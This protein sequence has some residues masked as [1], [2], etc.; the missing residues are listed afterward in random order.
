[1]SGS[2]NAGKMS[3]EQ[4]A[5]KIKAKHSL[6]GTVELDD[7]WFQ[8]FIKNFEQDTWGQRVFV[9]VEHDPRNGVASEITK[10]RSDGDRFL[11]DLSWKKLGERAFENGHIYFS[12]DFTD[13]YVDPETQEHHGP[14]L[15][16][17][18]M[19]TR[20][21]IKRQPSA[22]GHGHMTFSDRGRQIVVPDYLTSQLATEDNLMKELL[23][24]LK[25]HLVS[26]KLS[27]ALITT[28]LSAFETAG[29][30]LGDNKDQLDTLLS[31][32]KAQGD[33]LVKQ[34]AA[35]EPNIQLSVA[36]PTG[37]DDK[38][39]SAA[40]DKALSDAEA[41]KTQAA[42]QLADS[43]A[44]RQTLFDA[45]IDADKSLSE[46]QRGELKKTGAEFMA[47]QLSDDQVKS[48]ADTLLTQKRQANINAQ[49][50][51]MGFDV[52]G[53]VQGNEPAGGAG[54]QAGNFIRQVL[55]G[56][57]SHVNGN[58]MLAEEDKLTPF[59]KKV[60]AQFDRHN[61][62]QLHSEHRRLSGDTGVNIADGEFPI[63]AQRQVIVELLSDLRF[64]E[65]VNV[66]TDP[67]AQATTQI[68]Y[69]E[70]NTAGIRNGAIVPENGAISYAGVSQKMDIAYVLA[71]KIAVLV[72]NE[73]IHFSR[74]AQINWEAWGRSIASNARL[75]RELIT[76]AIAN[77]MQRT[78]DSFLAGSVTD[79]DVAA[80]LDGST[81]SLI[82][83]AK[84]PMVRPH[85]RVDLQGEAVGAAENPFTLS[86][87]GSEITAYDGSG[88]QAS[89]T[90]YVFENLNLGFVRL[91][92]QAGVVAT[93]AAGS[94][95]TVSYGFATNMIKVD[96][97]VPEGTKREDHL[98]QVLF[99]IGRRKATLK[100][101]RFVNGNF[102]IMSATLHNTLTEASQFEQQGARSGTSTDNQG[103][104]GPV[105]GMPSWGTD[106]PG[107]DLGE[108]RIMLGERGTMSYTVVKPFQT[109]T[110]FERVDPT[111]GQP[112]GQK[113][114]YGEEYSAIHVPKTI[115]NRLTSVIAYDSDARTAA[116]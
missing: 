44:A 6:Y 105:K 47:A 63:V 14:L 43:Q 90:Y 61:A 84:F 80:Q 7:D 82:K 58:L 28:L 42:K 101:E 102:S 22:Q 65:L 91:V 41:A 5:R 1:M 73:M 94:G 107:V 25:A 30:T 57:E 16:G 35:N 108:E 68:P 46:E 51:G 76:A 23:K 74:S 70:R 100:Q 59:A 86:I 114:A 4:F 75:M 9:D 103:T 34:L 97:K 18:G 29:K 62:R 26:L 45:E 111:T 53:V 3:T 93:P 110:P 10:L 2:V 49:L 64:L 32:F 112:T 12:I 20:P 92:D 40:V 21:F 36:T 54:G 106:E 99:A 113:Q 88:D 37:I 15:F 79:E 19:V 116:A 95:A 66:R 24:Q 87:N 109:G 104:L 81:K 60:L 71:R 38:V 77:E 48:L 11:A 56:T 67:S 31:Q 96:L 27:E 17:A 98:N 55:S 69:E 72:S 52:Q 33:E 89:G 85:Q 39:L 50:S 8:S 13:D 115:R 83:L 78:A